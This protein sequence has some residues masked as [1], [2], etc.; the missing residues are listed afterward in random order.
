MNRAR[1]QKLTLI[2]AL[3]IGL[4]FV[5]SLV[6]YA[7]RE[8]ISLFYT[9]SQISRHE[10][11]LEQS[12]R[13]GGL[14]KKHSIKREP[15]SIKVQFTLTDMDNDVVVYYEG[16]LPDLFR[17]EQGVVTTGQLNK[18]GQFIASQVL[19]K[20]DENYMPPEVKSSIKSAERKGVIN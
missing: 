12:I 14:V 15:G 20:H 9:P 17:E 10:A 19:A 2:I 18:N 11:P 13:L 6:M 8:N 16:I 7:L 5:I 1:R 4:M 3:L